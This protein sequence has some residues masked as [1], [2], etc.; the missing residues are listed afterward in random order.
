MRLLISIILLGG[1]GF[2][3][4]QGAAYNRANTAYMAQQFSQA[5]EVYDSLIREGYV[6]EDLFYNAGNAHY[7][8]GHIGSAI[9]NYER[10][11][12]IN[13]GN[14]NAAHNLKLAKEKTIDKLEQQPE[15]FLNKWF[16]DIYRSKNAS[17]WK[18]FAMIWIWVAFAFGALFIFVPLKVLKQ[19]GFFGAIL[20][21]VISFI[22]LGLGLSKGMGSALSSE[23]I[24]M[25][26]AAYI[27]EAPDGQTDLLIL[28]EGSKVKIL[29]EIGE[30]RKVRIE[31][32]ST[33]K[34][35]GFVRSEQVTKI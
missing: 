29:D 25:T 4:G 19:V 10:V 16:K 27:K 14:E 11:L 8:L 15:L 20:A 18:A 22:G 30:W 9:L 6:Y 3:F 26:P 34:V 12:K 5:A 35:E 7:K 32:I 31:A 13:P 21:A 2:T 17:Q 23:A 24:V 33:G 28:H 1:I